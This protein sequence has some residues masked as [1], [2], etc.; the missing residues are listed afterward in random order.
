M[1]GL[2]EAMSVEDRRKFEF[3]AMCFPTPRD[4]TTDRVNALFDS[5]IN[6]SGENKTQ[7]ILRVLDAKVD[8]LLFAD[9]SLDARVFA[10]AHER[11]ALHQGK[12]RFGFYCTCFDWRE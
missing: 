8:F 11:L 4:I 12:K 1:I 5:H 10:M 6:L 7:A 3:V 2:L 9:T